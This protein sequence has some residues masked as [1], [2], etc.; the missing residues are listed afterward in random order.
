MEQYNLSLLFPH[1]DEHST[2]QLDENVINDL[3]IDF[4]C[5]Y[6]ED[7]Q[8]GVARLRWRVSV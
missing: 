6:Q 5:E 2:R 7:E 4:I 8:A 3:S 1:K